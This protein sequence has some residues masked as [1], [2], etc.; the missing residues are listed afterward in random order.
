MC[1][2]RLDICML[3]DQV[4]RDKGQKSRFK[5][6]VVVEKVV[7]LSMVSIVDSL[8]STLHASTKRI[9]TL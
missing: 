9:F 7:D 6:G 4:I 8:L 1:L 3:H 2:N 5:G